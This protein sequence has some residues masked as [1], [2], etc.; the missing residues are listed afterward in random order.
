SPLYTGKPILTSGQSEFI[1]VKGNFS[2]L[3]CRIY[4]HV[5]EITG[6]FTIYEWG[7]PQRPH[8]PF[9]LLGIILSYNHSWHSK[10]NRVVRNT[11]RDYRV[12][13]NYTMTANCQIPP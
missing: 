12:S 11:A 7:A 6:M 8:A 1:T 4:A 9:F 5:S 13:G 10:H 3:P 2:L